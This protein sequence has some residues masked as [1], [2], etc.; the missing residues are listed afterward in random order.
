MFTYK[1]KKEKTALKT[2][3][4]SNFRGAYLIKI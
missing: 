3:D 4:D 2:I 1:L